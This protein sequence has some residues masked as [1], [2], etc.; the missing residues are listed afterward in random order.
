MKRIIVW[1]LVQTMGSGLLLLWSSPASAIPAFARW[2]GMS[3]SGCHVLWPV[4]KEA[5]RGFKMSGYRRFLGAELPP[6][7]PHIVRMSMS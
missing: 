7:T 5:G 4:L 6:A 1:C 3:C 2:Y